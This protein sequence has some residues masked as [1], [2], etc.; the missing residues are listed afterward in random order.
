[1]ALPWCYVTVW[2]Q[3]SW[4]FMVQVGENC[5]HSI[6][7]C[8]PLSQHQEPCCTLSTTR[9]VY[10]ANTPRSDGE[11]DRHRRSSKSLFNQIRG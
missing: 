2:P 1:M 8:V 10:P 7:I 6:A 3:P 4:K 9:L 5:S 11:Q